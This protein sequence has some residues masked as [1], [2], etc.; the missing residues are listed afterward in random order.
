MSFTRGISI[1]NELSASQSVVSS[2]VP[3]N[4]N[5]FLFTVNPGQKIQWK[6][7]GVMSTTAAAGIRLLAHCTV[8]PASYNAEWLIGEPGAPT[9]SIT[10]QLAEAAVTLAG[11]PTADYVLWAEGQITAAAAATTFSI[12][13]AQQ[14]SDVTAITMNQGMTLEIWQM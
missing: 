3:V 4:I 5:G 12:Q 11:P 2:I 14:A 9:T 10:A 6:L 7:R 1:V 13:F 8:A